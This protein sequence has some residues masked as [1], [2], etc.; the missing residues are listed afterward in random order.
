M[1]DIPKIMNCFLVNPDYP[2]KHKLQYP[3]APLGL[4]LIAAVMEKEGVDVKVEDQFASRLSNEALVEKI[5]AFNPDIIGIGSL[6][7]SITT[8]IKISTLLKAGGYEG[9]IIMGN[10]HP[11]IFAEDLLE[12]HHCH[13]VTRGEGEQTIAELVN[14]LKERR[15]FEDI[16][17]ISFRH[18]NGDIV[19]NPPRKQINDL[20]QLPFPAWHLFDLD[21]YQS[22][23]MLQL[24]GRAMPIQASRGCPNK[25]V[26]CG[27][28]IFANKMRFRSVKS[29]MNE[30]DILVDLHHV[31]YFV[32][33]DANF[34]GTRQYGFAFCDAFK[35]SRHFG[36]ISW[37]CELSVNLASPEIL[38]A[39]AEAG[40]RL[41]ILGFDA[42]DQAILDN[43]G[44]KTT[45]AQGE[46]AMRNARKAGLHVLGFFLIGLPGEGY[47]QIFRTIIYARRLD[48]DMA[49]FNITI[50]LPGSE[51]FNRH[52]KNLL[53]HFQPETYSS[54][55]R[56]GKGDPPMTVVPGTLS[57]K[58]LFILQA[59]AMAA[60]YIRVPFIIKRL[61][62][63]DLPV[64]DIMKGAVFL[65]EELLKSLNPFKS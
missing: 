31:D 16:A 3:I 51:L 21:L 55:Y 58:M 54:W 34:P 50:P 18:A 9:I 40:C 53:A 33:I 46:Q 65:L 13:I 20:N 10:V 30:I 27:Q 44:K 14:A 26:F 60:F 12:N 56:P 37:C 28:E 49:K 57:P 35:T 5:L 23:P 19:H 32:F 1:N 39:M 38:Q 4:A 36:K 2:Q 17:G 22:A 64:K 6:T 42:G 25:C 61:R 24:Y 29:V 41:I 59:I 48:C 43:I 45:L 15:G 7:P 47:R 11:T 52:K 63:K 8:A 62:Q